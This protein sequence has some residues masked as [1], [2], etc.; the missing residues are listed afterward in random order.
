MAVVARLK[1][2]TATAELATTAM[3]NILR[4]PADELVVCCGAVEVMSVAVATQ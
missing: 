3:E 4:E 1:V 2:A